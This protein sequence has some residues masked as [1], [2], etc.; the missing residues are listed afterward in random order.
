MAHQKTNSQK[1]HL[2]VHFC[3]IIRG[4]VFVCI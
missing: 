3:L 1:E 4:I 2:Q